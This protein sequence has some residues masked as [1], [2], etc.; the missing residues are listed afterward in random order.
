MSQQ[1]FKVYLQSIS[2]TFKDLPKGNFYWRFHKRDINRI[3]TTPCPVDSPTKETDIQLFK[4]LRAQIGVREDFVCPQCPHHA[5]CQKAFQQTDGGNMQTLQ[6]P[7]LSKFLE[8]ISTHEMNLQNDQKSFW[9]SSTRVLDTFHSILIDFQLNQNKL[10]EQFLSDIAQ[11]SENES[12]HQQEP[13]KK[14]DKYTKKADFLDDQ[15]TQPKKEGRRQENEDYENNNKN[16]GRRSYENSENKYDKFNKYERGGDKYN[17]KFDRSEQYNRKDRFD[18]YD[19]SQ[20]YDRQFDSDKYNDSGK[21][22]KYANKYDRYD[23]KERYNRK[24]RP[25]RYDRE[26][27]GDQQYRENKSFDKYEDRSQRYERRDKFDKY[28]KYD[29]YDKG[30]KYDK[31]DK[32]DKYEK[33]DK[34]DKYE[35]SDKAFKGDRFDRRNTDF[36]EENNEAPR[37][38]KGRKDDFSKNFEKNDKQHYE[39]DR[40]LKQ[41]KYA[42]VKDEDDFNTFVKQREQYLKEKS[43]NFEGERKSNQKQQDTKRVQQEDQSTSNENY[44][45][46]QPQGRKVKRSTKFKMQ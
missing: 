20:K 35:K 19:N 37:N 43:D 38:Y 5:K 17:S 33:S 40:F 27:N 25:Q 1:L 31:Y 3:I 14:T 23:N 32:G 18:K 10:N 36:S 12:I 41:N 4:E 30:D 7:H 13:N 46:E 16:Y 2:H 24:E 39:N 9:L 28:D 29:K 44:E 21:Y 45:E 26:A 22:D 11:V 42:K 34:F 8:T 6:L 15:N